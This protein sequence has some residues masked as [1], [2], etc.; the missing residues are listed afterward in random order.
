MTDTLPDNEIQDFLDKNTA[1][2]LDVNTTPCLKRSLKFRDFTAAWN[3]MDKVAQAAEDMNH[4]PDWS[5][6]YN[7]VEISLTSHDSG[8]LTSRDTTLA[9]L[10]EKLA[11][12]SAGH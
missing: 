12:D 10:I 11:T 1:W 7:R 9:E 8:G 3:F 2:S 4:H 5:N 6:S